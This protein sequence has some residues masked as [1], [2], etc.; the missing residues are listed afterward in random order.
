MGCTIFTKVTQKDQGG[1][2]SREFGALNIRAE[3]EEGA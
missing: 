3:H 2:T 1:R